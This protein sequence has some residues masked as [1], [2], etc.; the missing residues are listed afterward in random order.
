[1]TNMPGDGDPGVANAIVSALD[2]A[3]ID[4][5]SAVSAAIDPEATSTRKRPEEANTSR[6]PSGDQAG[7]EAATETSVT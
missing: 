2:H 3:G 4:P 6:C 7:G 5:G 1:M